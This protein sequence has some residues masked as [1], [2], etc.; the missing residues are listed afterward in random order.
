MSEPSCHRAFVYSI[1]LPGL[2]EYYAGAKK[3]ALL[4]FTLLLTFLGIVFTSL[5]HFYVSGLRSEDA[6][7]AVFELIIGTLGLYWVFLWAMISSIELSKRARIQSRTSEQTHPLWAL[8]MSYLCPG[9]GQVYLGRKTLGY[10]I[11]VLSLLCSILILTS[12]IEFFEQSQELLQNRG[13]DK[14]TLFELKTLTAI[15]SFGL[16]SVLETVLRIFSM[17]EA[18]TDSR[19]EFQKLFPSKTSLR[20]LCLALLSYFCP[21]SGQIFSDRVE[22]GM[23]FAHAFLGSKILTSLLMASDLLSLPS[24]TSMDWLSTVILWIALIEVSFRELS[25]TSSADE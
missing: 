12:C 22:L 20:P 15:V 21:G 9:S 25:P 6:S 3:R 13:F 24:I 2:G 17:I 23:V 1:A 8:L 4:S 19:L 7:G 10:C 5:Y 16:G 11:F 18:A 14:E